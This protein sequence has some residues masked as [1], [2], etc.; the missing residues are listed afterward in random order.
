[1]VEEVRAQVAGLALLLT[2]LMYSGG[3]VTAWFVFGTASLCVW[4][5]L[6]VEDETSGVKKSWGMGVLVVP[7]AGVDY[8]NVCSFQ[9]HRWHRLCILATPDV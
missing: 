6:V 4:E 3:G 2:S 1:M 8:A 9:E 7:P 5:V